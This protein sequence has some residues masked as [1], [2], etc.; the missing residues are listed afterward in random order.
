MMNSEEKTVENDDL[1]VSQTHRSFYS[2]LVP[3]AN[4]IVYKGNRYVSC[5]V[6]DA[7][8]FTLV[9]MCKHSDYLRTQ[10]AN[11][12]TDEDSFFNTPSQSIGIKMMDTILFDQSLGKVSRRERSGSPNSSY[13]DTSYL[14]S[15]KRKELQPKKWI[16][17]DLMGNFHYKS[18][19][20]VSISDVIRAFFV[21]L[22]MGRKSYEYSNEDLMNFIAKNKLEKIAVAIKHN[23]RQFLDITDFSDIKNRFKDGMDALQLYK[24]PTK[25]HYKKFYC[26]QY[27]FQ[28]NMDNGSY[29]Y[30]WQAFTNAY[31]EDLTD[32]EL[33]I[34]PNKIKSLSQ[35]VVLALE[36]AKRKIKV[37]SAKFLFLV[38]DSESQDAW[39]VGVE[40][41][42]LW[43]IFNT[44]IQG[45]TSESK[46]NYSTIDQRN[47]NSTNKFNSRRNLS[48]KNMRKKM[49]IFKTS[50]GKNKTLDNYQKIRSEIRK[51]NSSVQNNLQQDKKFK[52]GVFS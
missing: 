5:E 15:F 4:T 25:E 34:I 16:F 41:L 6:S 46:S 40:N 36:F 28:H 14:K 38:E 24:I 29:K 9:R 12:P 20:T 27:D 11:Q 21:N 48:S 31:I 8:Y 50:K 2:S 49:R 51:N 35:K 22:N 3:E 23:K 7:T 32:Q 1:D 47:L 10:M 30:Y 39:F 26:C 43:K 42:K 52:R 17:T 33:K 45:N 37:K 19:D 13:H 44:N 18:I